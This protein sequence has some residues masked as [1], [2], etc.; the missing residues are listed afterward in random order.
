MCRTRATGTAWP[1]A[2]CATMWSSRTK[3][4]RWARR[5]RDDAGL[6]PVAELRHVARPRPPDA[7]G[8]R[9]PLAVGERRPQPPEAEGLAED[10]GVHRDVHHQRMALALLDHL[11]ELVDD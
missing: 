3:S 11:V 4:R 10:V 6:Q 5:S 7:R 9:V 1:D 2:R 8:L